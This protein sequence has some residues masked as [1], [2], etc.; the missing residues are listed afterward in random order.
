M[1]YRFAVLL[2]LT[3]LPGR[4]ATSAQTRLEPPLLPD[5]NSEEAGQALAEKLRNSM[6]EEDT[7]FEAILK[8]RPRN[9]EIRHVPLSCQVI[10]KA[11]QWHTLYITKPTNDIPGETLSILHRPGQPNEYRFTQNN[12]NHPA[13]PAQTE[14][15]QK[16]SAQTLAGSDFWLI[17]LG[18]DFLHWPRQRLIR[19]EMRKSRWCHVLESR[20]PSAPTQVYARVLCWLDKEKGQPLLAEAYD[21]D[22]HLLKEFSIG[23]IKKINGQWQVQDMKIS[24]VQTRSRTWLEFNLN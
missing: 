12:T 22:N 16:N 1:S 24:N 14:L 9:G 20:N 7:Q 17:D 23:S 10:V 21:Q 3:W 19:T 18:M 11:D 6:P 4:L 2:L 8:T 5:I 13:P 15:S